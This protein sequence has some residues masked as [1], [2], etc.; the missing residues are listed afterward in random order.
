M[1]TTTAPVGMRWD[2]VTV[3]FGSVVAL[4]AVTFTAPAGQVTGL[5]GPNGA[6]KTT[7]LRV[8]LGHL[9]PSAGRAGLD[10]GPPAT[11]V[12]VG[13]VAEPVGL[14][15]EL[16]ARRNLRVAARAAGLPP[17]AVDAALERTGVAAVA[18]RRVRTLSTGQRQ[19]VALARALL[20]DPPCVVLDEPLNGLD[21]AGI[22]WLRGLVRELADAGRAVLLSSH[23]LAEVDQ[24]VDRLVVLDRRVHFEGPADQFDRAGVGIERRFFELLGSRP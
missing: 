2:G 10:P 11:A 3:R 24:V 4:D 8:L 19:R 18:G 9:R 17:S 13:V 1:A 16:S 23:L 22:V 6:G 7:C 14:D 15:P 21:P 5:L 12:P 20:G